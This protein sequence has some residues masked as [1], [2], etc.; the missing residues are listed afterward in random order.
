MR[1]NLAR[2]ATLEQRFKSKLIGQPEAVS[3]VVAS[4]RQI[5][6]GFFDERG[7]LGVWLF[8][9]PTGTGKTELANMVA[10]ELDWP[11]QRYDM[12]EYRDPHNASSFLGSPPG[13]VGSTEGGALINALNKTPYGVVLFD[14]FDKAHPSITKI[15]LQLF[16]VGRI[17]DATGHLASA[18]NKIIIMTMNLGAS[19]ISGG[20][21]TSATKKK[22]ESLIVQKFSPEFNGRLH[23]IAF[24]N[25][26]NAAVIA[27]IAKAYFH[28]LVTK[29]KDER[30]ITITWNE[31]EIRHLLKSFDIRNSGARGIQ[32][33]VKNLLLKKLSE[34][35]ATGAFAENDSVHVSISEKGEL[36]ISCLR[37]NTEPERSLPPLQSLTEP[38]DS[39]IKKENT[40]YLDCKGV[41]PM[42]LQGKYA[43]RNAASSGGDI[44]FTTEPVRIGLASASGEVIIEHDKD[45]IYEEGQQTKLQVKYITE[46]WVLPTPTCC[47]KSF[48]KNLCFDLQDPEKKELALEL[49]KTIFTEKSIR[50]LSLEKPFEDLKLRCIRAKNYEELLGNVV[51]L[52]K[53]LGSVRVKLINL[54]VTTQPA[55][56][57]DLPDSQPEP[58]RLSRHYTFN[59]LKSK[60]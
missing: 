50:F 51:A 32:R 23:K 16:D 40:V 42:Q 38:E 28:F 29:L 7:P 45:Y 26:L 44:S 52:E 53:L 24:F 54:P 31:A 3:A 37:N 56:P 36:R 22:L 14:E 19:L 21:W 35:Y 39:A 41:F 2:L 57:Y 4:I 10:E 27:E 33:S 46:H 18:K 49:V 47:A 11:I 20:P 15:F 59:F 48:F 30:R 9:G 34:H 58:E 6:T 55:N 43:I 8:A 12:T 1:S 13:Y 17:T 5:V 25:H 60:L